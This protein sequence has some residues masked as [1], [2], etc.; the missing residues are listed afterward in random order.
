MRPS[1]TDGDGHIVVTDAID[2]DQKISQSFP[3]TL[4][5]R[6]GSDW[7]GRQAILSLFEKEIEEWQH[8]FHVDKL[9]TSSAGGPLHLIHARL[10]LY[11]IQPDRLMC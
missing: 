1:A 9:L 8:I 3:S 4:L 11:I 6:I 7:I 10:V 5:N 2:K